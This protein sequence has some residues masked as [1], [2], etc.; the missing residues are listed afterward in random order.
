NLYVLEKFVYFFKCD[1]VK[2]TRKGIISE[3]RRTTRIGSSYYISLPK[4]F[5]EAHDIKEGDWLPVAANH[6]L[7]VIPM[8]EGKGGITM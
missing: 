2:V 6:I 7:K 1:N 3:P 8:A 5:L 4:E